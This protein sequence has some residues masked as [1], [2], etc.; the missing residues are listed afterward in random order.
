MGSHFSEHANL[1][2]G[3]IA[4]KCNAMILVVTLGS[5]L[6]GACRAPVTDSGV[7]LELVPHPATPSPGPPTIVRL[8]LAAEEDRF[9]VVGTTS[10]RSQL[11]SIDVSEHLVRLNEGEETL[12]E[13]QTLDAASQVLATGLLLVHNQAVAEFMDPNTPHRIVRRVEPQKPPVVRLD[14]PYSPRITQVE[15]MRI[16]P[17]EGAL[18]KEWARVPFGRVSVRLPQ[19]K[20]DTH[21]P[22]RSPDRSDG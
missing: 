13:Y 12:F 7:R 11:K 6:G 18:L 1:V 20:G 16:E 9:R 15:F 4:V 10:V 5:A 2:Q 3:E 21:E 19:S 17:L 8:I 14:I 22:Q